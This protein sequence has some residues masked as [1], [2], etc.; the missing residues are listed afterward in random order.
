[1]WGFIK[2]EGHSQWLLSV[3]SHVLQEPASASLLGWPFSLCSGHSRL[4]VSFFGAFCSLC[5]EFQSSGSVIIVS[6]HL[7]DFKWDVSSYQPLKNYPC[8]CFDPFP[9]STYYHWQRIHN[10]PLW[11]TPASFHLNRP[12]IETKT[13][14][15]GVP[16]RTLP[17]TQ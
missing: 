12:Y 16:F 8:P 7:S 3:N 2:R 4:L 9:S 1:M 5:P 15:W 17:E 13:L 14:S 11:V 6:P 10:L